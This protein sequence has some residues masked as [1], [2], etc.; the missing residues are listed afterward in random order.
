MASV[1]ADSKPGVPGVPWFWDAAVPAAPNSRVPG[2][3]C[4]LRMA[5][6]YATGS[7]C[8]SRSRPASACFCRDS[9]VCATLTG[10][11]PYFSIMS[12]N[13][14]GMKPIFWQRSPSMPPSIP[15]PAAPLMPPTAPPNAAPSK[16]RRPAAP[17]EYL[18][19][20]PPPVPAAA[21]S[22]SALVS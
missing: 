19:S 16:P 14:L 8:L 9:L 7:V 11:P 1:P 21:A 20:M 22:A 18:L 10:S 12:E 6:L 5:A 2:V 3:F 17:P 4:L 13:T 15:K